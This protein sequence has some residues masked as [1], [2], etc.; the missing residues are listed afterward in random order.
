M[1]SSSSRARTGTNFGL[2]LQLSK[3]HVVGNVMMIL[4]HKIGLV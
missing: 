1:Q 3:V 2:L 4:N